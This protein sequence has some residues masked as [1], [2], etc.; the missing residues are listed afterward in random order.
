MT[1]REWMAQVTDL[2]KLYGWEWAHFR[3]AMTSK[4]W[5]TPVSGTIGDGWPDLF[6]CRPRDRSFLFVELKRAGAKTTERQDDVI[7]V[8]RECGLTVLV[9]RPSDWPDVVE[10]LRDGCGDRSEVP[11]GGKFQVTTTELHAGVKFRSV[12]PFTDDAA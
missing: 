10:T 11:A 5:R 8:L 2:A 4:G 9:W 1:E 6:L 7:D 3:P 12:P